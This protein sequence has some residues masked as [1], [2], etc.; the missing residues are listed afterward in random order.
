M[1]YKAKQL[2]KVDIANRW[3]ETGIDITGKTNNIKGVF[4]VRGGGGACPPMEEWKKLSNFAF[5]S[6]LYWYSGDLVP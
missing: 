2:A 1:K 5:F 6:M 4:M 3:D